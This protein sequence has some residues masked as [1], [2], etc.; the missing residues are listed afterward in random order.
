MKEN[1]LSELTNFGIYFVCGI[2]IGI[3]FDIFRILRKSFKTPNLVTY[4]EDTIFGVITGLFIIFMFFVFSDGQL[5]FYIFISILLG[6]II[7][8]FTISKYFIKINV[9]IILLLKKIFAFLI[10]PFKKVAIF[11]VI[12]PLRIVENRVKSLFSKIKFFRQKNI[13]KKKDFHIKCRKYN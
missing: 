5:R 7:Y 9:S 12:K 8:F 3:F 10:S 13:R 6:A 1:I 2:I 11:L 4:I